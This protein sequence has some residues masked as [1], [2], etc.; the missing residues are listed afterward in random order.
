MLLLTAAS[1]SAVRGAVAGDLN[2]PAGPIAP[3]QRTP[4][5][6]NTT[7]GDADASFVIDSPGSYYLTGNVLGDA[8]RM[9]IEITV[10]AVSIDLMGFEVK[11]VGGSLEGIRRSGAGHSITIVNGTLRDWP[12]AG[13]DISTA[14]N[15]L[16]REVRVI[17]SGASGIKV[18]GRTIVDRCTSIE[19]ANGAG[20]ETGAGCIVTECATSG[21]S[22]GIQMG[23]SSTVTHCVAN[24]N[25][26]V[27]IVL[28]GG[29]TLSHCVI[30]DNT[31]D[32]IQVG[33]SCVVERA[34]AGGNAAS[35][36]SA[37][38]N[39]SR[40]EACHLASNGTGITVTG[41]RNLIVRNTAEDNGTDFQIAAGNTYGPILTVAAGGDLAV[42]AGG[43]HPWAN[44]AFTCTPFAEVCD[45]ADN[46]CNGQIDEND[47]NLG[48]PCDGID[49]D[50]CL[51]GT[52]SCNTGTLVCSDTTGSTSDLCNGID[53]D[54]DP[55]SSDG[56]EDPQTGTACDGPD[57]D[58]C[59]EGTRLCIGGALT[60]SDNTSSTLDLCNGIDDDCDP[61]SAD[62]SEDPQT[63]TACDGPDSDLCA[64]GTRS[65]AGGALTCS[66]NTSSTLDLCNG[67]NDDCDS[68][69]SDGSEDPQT[70]T[71]CD[72]PDT[73]LCMEGTRS[74]AGGSLVC[75]DNTGDNV[76]VCD[77]ADN[78]CDGQA[79]EG[80]C[81]N[82]TAC[83]VGLVCQ[84]G[85]CVDGVC[86][87]SACTAS[88]V[89]CSAAKKGSGADGTC[90]TIAAGT[91]PD[92][93]C[94]GGTPNCNGAGGCGP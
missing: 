29:G 18:G 35:G 19:N 20:I 47:P 54:C 73:D 17:N 4:I 3:T 63:G 45:G 52:Y 40:V 87:N 81:A 27:G 7:P 55:A 26:A 13:I 94:S 70:G 30:N 77:G 71:A 59:V 67:I 33:A 84:S 53:D 34:L 64:E 6:P 69:S 2:P 12:G 82:G 57:T 28:G 92:S 85:F 68:S 86:C 44:F 21:N 75:S 76:E 49:S 65:C 15:S 5:G 62:G 1:V 38:D 88:C 25:T 90:G 83:I 60:C 48:N 9:G 58:L 39:A 50:L 10:S 41:S 23:I 31:G 89:A 74:C 51:E 43:E 42:L 66:D 16:V 56:S 14:R 72:G 36:I 24:T 78:D 8:G 91:D 32:G 46:N 79:D 80:A 93:E 61:A 22:V 37:A 11:G